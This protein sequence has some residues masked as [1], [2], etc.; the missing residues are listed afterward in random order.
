MALKVL[1]LSYN[2]IFVLI[3]FLVLVAVFQLFLVFSRCTPFSFSSTKI[4][5]A[6]DW[7]I[8][9]LKELTTAQDRIIVLQQLSLKFLITMVITRPEL[10][11]L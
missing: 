9:N 8:A 6:V 7:C 11:H 2:V 5:L 4:T 1:T 10:C 3:Y